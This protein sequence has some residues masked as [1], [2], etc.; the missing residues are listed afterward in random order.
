VIVPRI[1]TSRPSVAGPTAPVL[2]RIGGTMR[3]R[4]VGP[5]SSALLARVTSLAMSARRPV[6]RTPWPR[7]A[8]N[9]PGSAT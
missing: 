8:V 4:D 9:A 3:C 2:T 7:A 5:I 6:T 1:S